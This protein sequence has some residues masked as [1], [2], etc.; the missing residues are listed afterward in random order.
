MAQT[1]PDGAIVR[2]IGFD[3][4][5]YI[6][7]GYDNRSRYYRLRDRYGRLSYWHLHKRRIRVVRIPEYVRIYGRTTRRL[8]HK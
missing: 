3:W 6:V 2:V 8:F 4:S 7:D 1:I 5:T